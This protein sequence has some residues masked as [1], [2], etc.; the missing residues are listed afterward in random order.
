MPSVLQTASAFSY[1]PLQPVWL[2]TLAKNR[3]QTQT[4]GRSRFYTRPKIEYLEKVATSKK[5]SKRADVK[6]APTSP[7]HEF[8]QVLGLLGKQKAVCKTVLCLYSKP[9]AFSQA[10]ISASTASGAPALSILMPYSSAPSVSKIASWE[11]SI[12]AFM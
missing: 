9:S 5:P 2:E 4:D 6:P 7:C 3:Q 11:S 12:P 10:K 1:K 8:Y